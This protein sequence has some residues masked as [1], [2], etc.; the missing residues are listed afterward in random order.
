M[1]CE[2]QAKM[3]TSV[4]RLRQLHLQEGDNISH[5]DHSG[6]EAQGW[7][8]GLVWSNDS[9]ERTLL[10]SDY[11]RSLFLSLL[12]VWVRPLGSA[13]LLDTTPLKFLSDIHFIA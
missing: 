3:Q 4:P 5:L 2:T 1:P 10:R 13:L 8:G 11:E 12:G 9:E 7:G 6:V